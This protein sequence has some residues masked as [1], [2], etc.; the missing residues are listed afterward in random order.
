MNA[1]F[2]AAA[3]S[4]AAPLHMPAPPVTAAD[5]FAINGAQLGMS[6]QAW[7]ALP[8]PG[9]APDHV[10]TK[11]NWIGAGVARRS[12]AAGRRLECRY[13]A[14][15]G[16]NE[17]PVSFPLSERIRIRKPV[18]EFVGGRLSAVRFRATTNAFSDLMAILHRGYGP[19]QRIVRD[20]VRVEGLGLPR[21]QATWRA[22]GVT[23]TLT[24]PSP[25]PNRLEVR[26]GVASG[27]PGAG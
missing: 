21:V 12:P 9:P 15:Y 4:L 17:L 3:A 14:K 1:I 20:I 22:A 26:L 2:A 13:V 8:R 19:P 23:V 25:N 24:A 18:F 27:P 6:L 7:Q 11:C 16:P 10:V 5:I